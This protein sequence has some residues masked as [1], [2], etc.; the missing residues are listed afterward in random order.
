M[1]TAIIIGGEINKGC[2]FFV[3]TKF[4]NDEER[5]VVIMMIAFL[6]FNGL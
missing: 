6:M 2:S 1:L 4:K 3:K 5:F